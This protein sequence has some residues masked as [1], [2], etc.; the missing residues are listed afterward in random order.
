MESTVSRQSNTPKPDRWDR[1]YSLASRIFVWGLFFGTLYLLRSFFLLIFLT[2]VFSYIQSHGA[3]KLEHRIKHRTLRVTIVGLLFL[4]TLISVGLFIVP[5]VVDQAKLFA[6]RHT[7]YLGSLDAQLLDFVEKYPI[8]Q[9]LIS[10]PASEE[11]EV[12]DQDRPLVSSEKSVTLLLLQ[13]SLG[14]DGASASKENVDQVVGLLRNIGEPLLSIGSAL[15]LSMMFSFL[16]ILDLPRLRQSMVSLAD[17]KLGFIYKEVAGSIVEFAS[18]LGRAFEAQL[19]IALANTVL[20]AGAIYLLGLQKSI[21]FLSLIVFFCSFIPVAGVFISSVPI[22]LLAMQK[23]GFALVLGAVALIWI[24]H[25][26]EAYV[27]NPRIYGDKLKI[28][29]VLVLIILTVAGKLFGVWGLLLSLPI[30]TYVF[31]HAIKD[32]ESEG[33]TTT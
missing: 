15:L 18:V 12:D 3:H 17:T 1:V 33:V 2:F 22:C 13:R 9:P 25:I 29:P 5:R 20:T 19:V 23:A 6:D 7:E 27:L 30:Y 8:A 26:I 21:A 24:V 10:V 32:K 11:F 14:I 4:S 28:N 31:G 16:I